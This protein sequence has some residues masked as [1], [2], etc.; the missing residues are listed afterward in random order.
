MAKN[1]ALTATQIM[2][3]E[4]LRLIW[5]SKK[6]ELG[7]T[8]EKVA[9]LCQ[10]NTQAAF[11][12][13]L[14]A[15]I[16]LNTE[17]ILRLSKVFQIHPTEIMPALA[18]ILP[19]ND[20]EIAVQQEIFSHS[21]KM[22]INML[23][24]VTDEKTTAIIKKNLEDL[25]FQ[26]REKEQLSS[27]LMMAYE[28]I[29][30]NKAQKEK[31]ADELEVMN[32]NLIAQYDEKK[33]LL[34]ELANANQL[35]LHQ[36]TEKEKRADEL[37]I[38]NQELAFQNTEKDKRA[39]ELMIINKQNETLNRE[40]NHLQKVESLGRLT[41]GISHDFNNILAC[42]LGYN[43]MNSYISEEIKDERLKSELEHNIQ[44][45]ANAGQR[46]VAL[47]DKMM[48]YARQD[49]QKVK[50]INI[51]HTPEVINEMVEM[52][53]PA[54][55]SRIKLEFV[56]N[57]DMN[58]GNCGDCPLRK[59]CNMS[60]KIDASDLH[61]IITNLAMNA[62]DA[63]KK[64][65]GCITISLDKVTTKLN[66]KCSACGAVIEGNFVELGVSDNGT[67]IEPETITR[68]FDP[69]FTTKPQGEGTGLGLSTLTGLV[70]SA[71]GH[72]V[73]DSNLT[74]PNQGTSFKLLFPVAIPAV[75]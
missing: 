30:S 73:V 21:E 33:K 10:W 69:F 54:L 11:N 40:V 31:R 59:N 27:E 41:A 8:Q 72:I 7:L 25:A 50:S 34:S 18:D 49:I 5:N 55:T 19:T 14:Q 71:L 32:F 2:A 45:I 12:A 44:Q 65:G 56:N 23:R 16:P 6:K 29:A 15:R 58:K 26:Y 43:E 36:N 64:R 35:L 70:H 20:L 63:M 9:Q 74:E 17:A 39:A 68:I 13:Y 51:K 38:A 61:Q 1:I 52:L 75:V 46:A 3:A 48:T 60:I 28:E 62:R 4:Q 47:I 57:C 67:G 22:I 24:S 66:T 53:R 42:M 37:M